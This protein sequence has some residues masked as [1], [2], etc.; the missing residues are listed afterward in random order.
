MKSINIRKSIFLGC[1]AIGALGLLT[2]SLSLA[3]GKGASKLMFSATTSQTQVQAASRNDSHMSCCS[4]RYVAVA[5]Q[6]AKGMRVGSTKMVPNHAC[7]S[8][9]TKI[10]SVGVGKAKT[11]KVTHSCDNNATAAGS[12]C[13][14]TK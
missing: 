8:C 5:D 2:P 3:D 13:V 7:S 6:S 1:L 11:D 10:T 14:A 12:C 9:Q 4:D